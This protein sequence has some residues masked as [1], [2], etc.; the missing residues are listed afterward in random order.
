M[1][2]TMKK[3]LIVFCIGLIF[4]SCTKKSQ[5]QKDTIVQTGET[6]EINSSNENITISDS[7]ET[8]IIKGNDNTV[9]TES[10]TDNNN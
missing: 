7:T 4:T 5:N 1:E 8:I 3:V 6:V 9:N 10:S 2:K